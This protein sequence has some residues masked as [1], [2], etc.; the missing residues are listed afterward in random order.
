[1]ARDI[2]PFSVAIIIVSIATLVM[3]AAM[4][5]AVAIISSMLVTAVIS[6][7]PV[8]IIITVGRRHV[9]AADNCGYDKPQ[10]NLACHGSKIPST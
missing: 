9:Q 8:L 3:P 2:N 7:P 6:P 10:H 4:P 1:V 5:I